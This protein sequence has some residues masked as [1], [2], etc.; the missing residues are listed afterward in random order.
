MYPSVE[1]PVKMLAAAPYAPQLH[2]ASHPV[3]PG[4]AMDHASIRAALADG[5]L[6]EA[7]LRWCITHLVRVILQADRYE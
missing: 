7:R 3:M 5:S 2:S 4:M 1:L 6:T